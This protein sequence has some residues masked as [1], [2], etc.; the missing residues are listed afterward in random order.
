MRNAEDKI[1]AI[2]RLDRIESEEPTGLVSVEEVSSKQRFRKK[3]RRE[4]T[5]EGEE[6]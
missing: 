6:K 4:M 3:E 1:N 2:R 5:R